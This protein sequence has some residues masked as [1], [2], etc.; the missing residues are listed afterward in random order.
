MDEAVVGIIEGAAFVLQAV[1]ILTAMVG[2]DETARRWEGE[3]LSR[4]IGRRIA[5]AISSPV[6]SVW[7]RVRPPHRAVGAVAGH[8][9]ASGS[10]HGARAEVYERPIRG[11]EDQ[12]AALRRLDSQVRVIRERLDRLE[13]RTDASAEALATSIRDLRGDLAAAVTDLDQRLAASVTEGLR[14][15]AFGLLITLVGLALDFVASRIA[16]VG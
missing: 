6:R 16:I 3:R 4:R 15:T 13:Q 2:L 9:S 12:R 10:A 14:L 5:S 1:G 7:W 11:N 8:A